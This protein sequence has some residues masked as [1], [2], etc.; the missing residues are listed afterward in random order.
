MG[1]WAR[2]RSPDPE[3]AGLEIRLAARNLLFASPKRY[4]RAMKGW[5][6]DFKDLPEPAIPLERSFDGFLGL[7]WLELTPTSARVRFE[8]RENLK[9]SLGLLHGGIYSAVAE[10]VA[11]TATF[12]AV[13]PD[14]FIGLGSRNA[15]RFLRPI[16]GGHALVEA[17][18]K[19]SD[20][21]KCFWT[22][23][24]WDD[25]HRLCA[26]VDV[27]VAVRRPPS[28]VSGSETGKTDR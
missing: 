17:E 18:V 22:H 8:V 4:L 9:Q 24:F 7:E 23:E 25:E 11:S 20:D 1:E 5:P 28:G 10:T 21:H 16:T 27:T 3:D 12:H 6:L 14:G 2:N 26:L 19:H 13:W 15:A